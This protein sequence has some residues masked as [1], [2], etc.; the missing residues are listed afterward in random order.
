MNSMTGFGQ[1]S[2][3]KS[4]RQLDVN[5]R[6]YNGR[7]LELKINLPE[8]LEGFRETIEKKLKAKFSRGTIH[9]KASQKM[10]SKGEI[11][12][13]K[14]RLSEMVE[15]Y[16]ELKTQFKKMTKGEE[17]TFSDF[18][19]IDNGIKKPLSSS[20]GAD[21][22]T[23]ELLL[24][25]CDDAIKDFAEGRAKEGAGLKKLLDKILEDMTKLRDKV[26]EAVK[27]IEGQNKKRI[28]STALDSGLFEKADQARVQ[29]EILFLIDRQSVVE[30]LG[31]LQ[32]H[33][34]AIKDL[35]R[36][37]QPVGKKLE[38]Y[39]QEILRE[40]NTIGSKIQSGNATE[41]VVNFKASIENFREQVQNVE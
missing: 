39:G 26:T 32:L 5:I 35:L 41:L 4:N 12:K 28:E 31:R 30:E 13:S 18:I 8:E 33:F 40:V 25:A 20:E 3:H 29:Q 11:A 14:Q 15:E 10:T 22:L 21:K 7:H 38:F 34:K 37:T 2:Q 19:K 16:L 1:A 36:Q 6:S 17:L 23:Q 27:E 24:K 9:L